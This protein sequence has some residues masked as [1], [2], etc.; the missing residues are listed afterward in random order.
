MHGFL[1]LVL[2]ALTGYSRT[3]AFHNSVPL[4]QEGIVD[5]P[6][7]VNAILCLLNAIIC[8]RLVQDEAKS[9]RCYNA[10]EQALFRFFKSRCGCNPLQFQHILECG[11]FLDLPANTVIPH[12]ATS[13][14][15]VL[16]GKI[17]CSAT[18]SSSDGSTRTNYFLKRSGQFF[19]VKLFN[20]FSIP[21]GF[22]NVDFH[23]TTQ[24][25][26]KL[27]V[28]TARRLV[29]MR[30][31]P[32]PALKPYWEYMVLRAVAGIAV[33]HHLTVNDT[34]YDSLLVPEHPD[35]LEGAPSR[36]FC[37]T[38]ASP[39]SRKSDTNQ[40]FWQIA[41]HQCR[42]MQASICRGIIPPR[43]VR[44]RPGVVVPNPKQDY[45][46][47]VLLRTSCPSGEFHFLDVSPKQ[48]GETQSDMHVPTTHVANGSRK[49]A[50]GN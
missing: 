42:T 30:D 6:M 26:A 5:I 27:F 41:R 11:Q 2:S 29:V 47:M 8:V 24:T 49:E 50:Q 7:F 43:G 19:D 45:F 12:C 13:L 9:T 39:L 21:V 17:E 14:Y 35:W 28:W 3:G 40:T 34:L 44:Q 18:Y 23:A 33:R 4:V 38:E 31:L 25:K 10:Q 46:E 48:Q 22:D 1:F 32:S 36:D 37:H 20:L 16:Q 15:L